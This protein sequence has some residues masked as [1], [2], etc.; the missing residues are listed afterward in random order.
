MAI[1]F[2]NYDMM[3]CGRLSISAPF[4]VRWRWPP[5]PFQSRERVG[6]HIV[7]R[8]LGGDVTRF[9]YSHSPYG[10]INRLL[11]YLHHHLIILRRWHVNIPPFRTRWRRPQLSLSG[12]EGIGQHFNIRLD[13]ATNYFLNEEGV[14]HQCIFELTRWQYVRTS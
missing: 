7:I 5:H 14:G 3:W 11:Y 6:H 2:T 8:L 13:M 12:E 10:Y 9:L 1:G 4:Q